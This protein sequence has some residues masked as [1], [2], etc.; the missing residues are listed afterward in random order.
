MSKK[1]CPDDVITWSSLRNAVGF[2]L[3]AVAVLGLPYLLG[4]KSAFDSVWS[5]Q[6]SCTEGYVR[7]NIY[8]E[9]SCKKDGE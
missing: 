5:K 6:F 3:D 7:K 1:C 9:L 4:R 8:D 2:V